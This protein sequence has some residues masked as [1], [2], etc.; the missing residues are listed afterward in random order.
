MYLPSAFAQTDRQALQALMRA[1]PFATLFSQGADGATADH[2]PLELD[3]GVGE[4]GV[5]RGHVAR[6][7]P[8]WQQAVGQTVLVV[9]Q[10]PQA[11]VTPSWYAT[12]AL[13]H[14]VV[15]TWNYAIV[16]AR[17]S[18]QVVQEAP[19]LHA[20]VDRLTQHHEFRRAQPWAVGD[21]P[22][23]YIQNLL[24][25]IVGI[26]ITLTQV[27]GKFKLSQN[28]SRADRE[29]VATGLATDS[30]QGAATAAL[31]QTTLPPEPP[32]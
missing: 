24:R 13:T 19:W 3:P 6:A 9:F 27:L 21:A 20:L 30:A 18:L 14:Q 15:P 10:G 23:D 7:N 16:H 8:L 2:L 4:H 25:A 11:Y 22:P 1:H 28:R 5:L 31:M 17:G 29:G 32:R 26:E 12:K